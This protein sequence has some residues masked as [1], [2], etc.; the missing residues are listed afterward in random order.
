VTSESKWEAI[1]LSN[2][3]KPELASEKSRILAKG[4][5]VATLP[6]PPGMDLGPLRVWLSHTDA[7]GLAMSRS[8]GDDVAHTVGVT[9]EPEILEYHFQD[10]DRMLI[11]ATDGVWE[12]LSSEDVSQMVCES[13]SK[14]DLHTIAHNIAKKSHKLWRKYEPV[15]D[16]ISLVIVD[17][18][19][20]T[21][22]RKSTATSSIE[23][24]ERPFLNQSSSL[25]DRSELL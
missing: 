20:L 16:D 21:A 10:A 6:G 12:F 13:V 4:G 3:H 23:M 17:L 1:P 18:S 24:E 11:L 2:D 22:V 9:S 19:S 14:Y 15:V 8:F 5:R 7:P 25:L